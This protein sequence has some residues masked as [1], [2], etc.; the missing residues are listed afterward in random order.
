M[1]ILTTNE[2]TDKDMK[3][4]VAWPYSF[5]SVKKKEKSNLNVVINKYLNKIISLT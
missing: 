4:H 1:H 5:D 2:N 3:L